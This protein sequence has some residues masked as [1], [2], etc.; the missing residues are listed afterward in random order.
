MLATEQAA[1]L[2]KDERGRIVADQGNLRAYRRVALARRHSYAELITGPFPNK[3]VSTSGITS[4]QPHKH[5]MKYDVS[6]GFKMHRTVR[7]QRCELNN[8]EMDSNYKPRTPSDLRTR[9]QQTI[10]A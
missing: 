4:V 9:L 7:V 3:S 6:V 8:K 1:S 10:H 5:L 2:A